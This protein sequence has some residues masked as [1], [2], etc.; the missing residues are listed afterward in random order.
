[1]SFENR[2]LYFLFFLFQRSRKKFL[3]LSKDLRRS[4]VILI[5]AII[6]KGII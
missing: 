3:H 2:D 6:P 4:S 5:K 1:M